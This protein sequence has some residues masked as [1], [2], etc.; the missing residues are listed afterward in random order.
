[1]QYIQVRLY[2][3][4]WWLYVVICGEIKSLR[5]WVREAVFSVI[6]DEVTDVAKNE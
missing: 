2:K 5:K 4:K 6:A 3:M 1:M